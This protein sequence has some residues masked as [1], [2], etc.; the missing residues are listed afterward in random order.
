MIHPVI[1][2]PLG[3]AQLACIR[4]WT[5]S[6]FA[7]GFVHVT[8][9]NPL[10]LI[11][12][13]V[14]SYLQ[15]SPDVLQTEAGIVRLHDFLS[16]HRATGLTCLSYA[17]AR[18]LTRIKDRLPLE[19]A[20]WVTELNVI[21]TLES[22]SMQTQLARKVGLTLLRSFEIGGLIREIIPDN[23]FPLVVRPDDPT[24]ISPIF[25]M[26]FIEDRTALAA[27]VARFMRIDRPLIAQPYV[28][29]RNF[30]VHGYRTR[31]GESSHQG[32]LVDRMLDGVTLTL[33]PAEIPSDLDQKCEQFVNE[34]GLTGI[35]H[36]EFLHEL[37]SN[38]YYFLEINGRLGGTTA[39]VYR[40][41]FDEPGL[42]PHCY[43]KEQPTVQHIIAV[44]ATSKQALI[45]CLLRT[46]R[47][48]TTI[49][50][51]P[52][53]TIGDRLRDLLP[54]LLLWKDEIIDWRDLRTTIAYF[55]QKIYGY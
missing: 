3:P 14:T 26:Q 27:F 22:K 8:E 17:M 53:G 40:C 12:G 13:A 34:L 23:A 28:R 9:G 50:D 29:G 5:R 10:P 4:S 36:F 25:K 52:C 42:I 33:T 51:Y 24:T 55:L 30:V 38:L 35:Y 21:D 1:L 48:D 19:T 43:G 49:F 37:E 16:R 32:F 11:E 45:K 18:W 2:G 31:S 7:V 54:G 6:G 41:G 47:G 20:L 15:I 44:T 46:F 39:K